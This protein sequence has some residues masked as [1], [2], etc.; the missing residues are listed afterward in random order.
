MME[1]LFGKKVKPTDTGIA[2]AAR[3]DQFSK[4]PAK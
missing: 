1:I 4:P 3:L 2:L